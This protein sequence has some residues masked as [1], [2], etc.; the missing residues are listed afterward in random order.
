M[1]GDF[2]KNPGELTE[3]LKIIEKIDNTQTP[4]IKNNHPVN[5]RKGEN[6]NENN[7]KEN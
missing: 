2:M 3:L 6:K 5:K 1:L 7:I 4:Q